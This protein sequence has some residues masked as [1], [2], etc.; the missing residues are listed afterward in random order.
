MTRPALLV[1]GLLLALVSASPVWPNQF[2]FL[3]SQLHRFY[4]STITITTILELPPRNREFEMIWL[5]SLRST[6]PHRIPIIP[7][8]ASPSSSFLIG[9]HHFKDFLIK[10]CYKR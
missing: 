3:P 5:L 10:A 4:S 8:N 1:L 7:R 6:F 2:R 9:F